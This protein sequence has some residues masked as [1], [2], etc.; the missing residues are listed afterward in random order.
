MDIIPGERKTL[1][2]VTKYYIHN[3]WYVVTTDSYKADQFELSINAINQENFDVKIV[4][5]GENVK[6]VY[7]YKIYNKGTDGAPEIVKIER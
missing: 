5:S 2:I 1:D 6:G 3:D 7:W 4:I